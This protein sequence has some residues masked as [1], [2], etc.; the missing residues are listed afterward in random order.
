MR[1]HL[2]HSRRT[3][4]RRFWPSGIQTTRSGSG[5]PGCATGEEVFS[6]AI[7]L[8]E[9]IGAHRTDASV[10]IFGTDIDPQAVAFA[11]AARFRRMDGMSAERLQRWFVKDGEDYLPIRA[12]REMCVFSEH[13]LV[14]D[15]PFSKI[16]LVSCRNVL[17]YM[18]N[19][20]QHNYADVSLCASAWW[21]SVHRAIRERQPRIAAVQRCR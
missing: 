4:C 20:F 3:S 5:S 14:R 13:N 11:R 18:D 15:P 16:D 6:I 10:T 21:L 8:Q 7:L 17:I 1:K 2:K 12:I 9:T 19:D